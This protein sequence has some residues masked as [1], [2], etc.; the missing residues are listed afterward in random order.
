[1]LSEN[2]NS[3]LSYLITTVLK[4]I[5]KNSHPTP[6]VPAN[7][8]CITLRRLTEK[9]QKVTKL[10]NL[11]FCAKYAWSIMLPKKL[12]I[13]NNVTVFSVQR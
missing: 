10:Q 13:Y 11:P 4:K 9:L 2:L 1:M 12:I 6:D 5:N 8:R 3:G 7:C